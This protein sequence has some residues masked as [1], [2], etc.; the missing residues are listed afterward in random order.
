MVVHRQHWQ[1]RES[2]YV[3]EQKV[4]LTRQWKHT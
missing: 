3:P 1:K 2:K 4:M